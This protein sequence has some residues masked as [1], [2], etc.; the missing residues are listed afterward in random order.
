MRRI[1]MVMDSVLAPR[2]G[3]PCPDLRI[4]TRSVDTWS[5]GAFLGTV[6][7]VLLL[8]I[9]VSLRGN[10]KGRRGESRGVARDLAW[11]GLGLLPRETR[12]LLLARRR[13][14]SLVH[15]Y[16]LGLALDFR[17]RS[18]QVSVLGRVWLPIRSVRP[19]RV[20]LSLLFVNRES[21][22]GWL[23]LHLQLCWR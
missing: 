3:A 17:S 19:A 9:S 8:P 13:P 20:L 22:I 21:R 1:A 5:S 15:R 11:L 18:E 10:G 23:C 6:T 4:L 12:W 7:F 2:V 14:V 16:R